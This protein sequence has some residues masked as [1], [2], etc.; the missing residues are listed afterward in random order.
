MINIGQQQEFTGMISGPAIRQELRQRRRPSLE[1]TIPMDQEVS[2]TGEGW[3]VVRHNKRTIRVRKPKPADQL[4]EDD[5]WALFALMGFEDMSEGRRFRIPIGGSSPSVPPKQIDVLAFDGDTALVIECK[6]S[7][8]PRRRSLQRDLNETRGL[9]GG[10]RSTIHAHF[11][12][13]PRVCFVYVTRNIRW[14]NQD[15][16][17]A[18]AHHISIIR[19]RQ[20][21]YY[22][23]L[24]DIIGPAARHQLQADLLEGSPVQGL[25]ATVPAL[26]GRFGGNT[27]YQFAIEPDRLLKLA[28]VSHRSKIDAE[29]VGTYQRLLRK[30]RLR[31]ISE[32]INETG[33]VFPTNVVINF[34][35]SRDLR[36]DPA[37]PSTDDP[38]VLGTLHLPNRYK[39]AWV[40]DGQ[41]RLYGFSLSDWTTRGRIPV[42]AFEN[43]DPSEEV[44]MF[45]EINSK[46]V[47]VPRSLLVELEPELHVSDD[48]PE[49]R[50]RSLHSQLAMD[51]SESDDSPLWDRVVSE[52]E[53]DARNR[54]ITLPQLASAIAE[55][56]LIGSLRSGVLHP[57]FLYY[58][59]WETTRTKARLTIE[60]FLTL[61]SEGAPDHWMRE[62]SAGGF[63]CTNLAIAALLRLFN[64][65]LAYA[66]ED[67]DD[68][69]YD[70]LT[71]DAIVGTVS[72]L[73]TPVIDWFKG[74]DDSKM[75]VFRGRYGSGA[76][77]AYEFSLMEIIH[78][79]NPQFEPHGL[80]DHIQAHSNEAVNQAQQLITEIEDAVRAMTITTLMRKYGEN[81]DNWWRRGVPQIVRGS[82]AQR[83]ETSEE[84]GDAHQFLDLLDYK[85]IAEMPQNWSDFQ[86]LF[87]VDQAARSKK[88]KLA[89]MDR[90]NGIRNRVS[91]SG[92]RHV[93]PEELVFLE[94]VWV[95]VEEQLECA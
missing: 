86:H 53:P 4:L 8:A 48:R 37:G 47:K 21:D 10:I 25:R 16:E 23:R 5:V 22:R 17:R 92:R 72:T 79:V 76:P 40:I 9:Q 19:D 85:K 58:R 60:R 1:K 33:G 13:R 95:H 15:R 45:V 67:R 61:F 77:R 71:A 20:I 27:F 28:Y 41:H 43:L 82:A 7:E 49:Q 38:T 69:E 52:W 34:R 44:R 93:R 24:V 36:F 83:A 94:D 62:R 80:A 87:T 54:P 18:K 68:L 78:K 74:A 91:H 14:S 88:D 6:A 56:Q 73:I 70:R 35:N 12:G 11:E 66:K 2:Y 75:N 42:L 55:S 51:L 39:C 29:A 50:L 59:D 63:L 26:R 64:S 32:H 90:L 65:A 30:K 3:E 81:P 46:Q 84:G 31:D 89:W 57:G